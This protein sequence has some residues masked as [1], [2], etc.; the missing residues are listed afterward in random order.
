[1]S[2]FT[3]QEEAEIRASFDQVG[4]FLSPPTQ[5]CLASW[6]HGLYTSQRPSKLLLGRMHGMD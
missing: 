2:G 4:S 5:P 3:P 1:M 6:L